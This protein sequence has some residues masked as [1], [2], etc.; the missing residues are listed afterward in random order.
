MGSTI[1]VSAVELIK[2][3]ITTVASSALMKPPLPSDATARGNRAKL[4]V[5]AVMRMGRRRTRAPDIRAS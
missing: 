2:P 5:R 1:S 4:V 3:P